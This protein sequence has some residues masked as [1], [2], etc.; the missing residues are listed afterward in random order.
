MVSLCAQMTQFAQP[1]LVNV[2][3]LAIH[4]EPASLMVVCETMAFMEMIALVSATC[5]ACLAMVPRK[6]SV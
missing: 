1:T 3:V 6:I 5:L 4:M 2:S